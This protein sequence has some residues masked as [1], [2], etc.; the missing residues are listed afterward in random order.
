MASLW[1]NSIVI[2]TGNEGG[3]NRHTNGIVKQGENTTIDLIVSNYE[4]NLNIQLWKNY[5]DSYDVLLRSPG[6]KIVG[7]FQKELG[8]QRFLLENTE[9]LLYYGEP[10]PYSISQEIY[11][12]FLPMTNESYITPGNWQFILM[13]HKIVTG[14]Y[15]MWLPAGNVISNTTGFLLP[16]PQSTLTI[17]STAAKA[18]TVG[19]YDSFTD[20]FANFSGRGYKRNGQIKPDIV[21][22]GVNI[23]GAAPGGGYTRKTGTSMATPMVAGSCSLL[24]EW[25]LIRG[26][27]P[28]LYGEKIKAFLIEGAKKVPGNE[29][30]GRASCRERVLRLV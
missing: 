18:L 20:S 13:P 15:D 23:M 17:P 30:I 24:L 10:T 21:A 4:K 16:T 12:E 6:G 3:S 27:D 28:Y 8:P 22:P 2:G 9:I 29:K 25:G 1:K 5:N 11:I 14:D 19:A 7:P 26:N